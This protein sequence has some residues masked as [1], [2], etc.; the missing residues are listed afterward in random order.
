MFLDTLEGR[1]AFGKQYQR[2]T[3][4]LTEANK[5]PQPRTQLLV[6]TTVRVSG[7]RELLAV[8]A[9]PNTLWVG[10]TVCVPSVQ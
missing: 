6:D 7:I 4:C 3:F 2:T 1:E 9:V 8:F 10:V 5:E